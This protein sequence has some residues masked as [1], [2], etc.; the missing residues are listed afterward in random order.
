MSDAGSDHTP[1]AMLHKRM[2]SFV[3]P[4]QPDW[5]KGGQVRSYMNALWVKQPALLRMRDGKFLRARAIYRAALV[6][7][8]PE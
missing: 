1:A 6:A 5:A 3:V 2:P 7:P 4:E 8:S